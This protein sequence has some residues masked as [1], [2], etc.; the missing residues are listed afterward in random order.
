M[1]SEG[2][3]QVAAGLLEQ[4]LVNELLWVLAPKLVGQEGVPAVGAL[5][6]NKMPDAIELEVIET[7]QLGADILLRAKI[8]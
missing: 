7:R 8:V 3:G 5:G 1:V 4:R 2:G 6:C